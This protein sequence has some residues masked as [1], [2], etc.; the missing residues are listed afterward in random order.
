MSGNNLDPSME[1]LAQSDQ[2]RKTNADKEPDF[3]QLETMTAQGAIIKAENESMAMMARMNPRNQQRSLDRMLDEVEANPSAAEYYWYKIPNRGEGLTIRAAEMMMRN[4]GN[5][6]A[7][8]KI[9]SL[10]DESAIVEGQYIDYETMVMIRTPKVVSRYS[11]RKGK[12]MS[13]LPEDE[14]ATKID[15]AASKALRNAI[16]RSIPVHIKAAFEM[17]VK[18]LIAGQVDKNSEKLILAFMKIGVTAKTLERKIGRPLKKL[19]EEEFLDLRGL[20]TA[21]ESGEISKEQAFAQVEDTPEPTD[22]KRV[23]ADTLKGEAPLPRPTAKVEPFPVVK[24]PEPEPEEEE[25]PED[26]FPAASEPGNER[27]VIPKKLSSIRKSASWPEIILAVVQD[28]PG[29][30]RDTIFKILLAADYD[31]KICFPAENEDASVDKMR[32]EI[33]RSLVA[34]QKDQAVVRPDGQYKYYATEDA[35]NAK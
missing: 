33:A 12:G 10:Q 26:Q 14:Y 18:Q 21:I 32:E 9:V 25:M 16:E 5:C 8:A 29:L 19:S 11:Y 24:E 27:L 30:T 20:Y 2:R 23:T 28:D 34:L 4:W 1:I 6:G 15:A 35:P 13:R 31:P 22:N 17:R 7:G 3:K